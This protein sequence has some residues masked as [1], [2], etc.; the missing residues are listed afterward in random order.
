MNI[1]RFAVPTLTS[2]PT[3]TTNAC[4]VGDVLIDPA[5]R[6][7]ALDAAAKRATHVTV[8]HT[9]PDHIGALAE[10]ADSRTVW[11]L[12]GHEDRFE[13]ATGITPD[14]TFSDGD[15]LSGL[16]VLETPGHFSDHVAFSTGQAVLCG[17]LAMA[18]SSVFVGGEGA[19]MAAY[20]DSLERVR[21]LDCKTL[22]PGHGEPVTTPKERLDWLINHRLERERRVKKAIE[23][24][25]QEV[26]TIRDASYKKDLSGVEGLAALTVKAH[27]E[28]LASED[29]I[30]WDGE[31]ASV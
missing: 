18:E 11:T 4:L 12:S 21:D 15:V 7:D 24:G 2:A 23:A 29:E 19:D 8:T 17:D 31:R 5:A 13:E 1:D 10:Y 20:L 27:L 16:A 28:K 3:G 26:E 30:Q 14:R 22:H 6:T 9:H 25:N